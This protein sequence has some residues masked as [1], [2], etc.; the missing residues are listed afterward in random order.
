[1][2]DQP[3]RAP[4][5][6]GSDSHEQE[7]PILD[8]VQ[9]TLTVDPVDDDIAR[10][11]LPTVPAAQ[12]RTKPKMSDLRPLPL[13]DV[14]QRLA[15]LAHAPNSISGHQTVGAKFSGAK[16]EAAELGI[17]S[18]VLGAQ[19]PDNQGHDSSW[20]E[21]D[22]SPGAGYR[23]TSLSEAAANTRIAVHS[24]STRT[25]LDQSYILTD[26]EVV[27]LQGTS[28]YRT[29]LF[30]S[31]PTPST[32][33]SQAR[34]IQ[35]S[36]P[37]TGP[38]DTDYRDDGGRIASWSS[39][40]AL[41]F[42]GLADDIAQAFQ[43]LPEV[44]SNAR[45]FV[46]VGKAGEIAAVD[47]LI[48]NGFELVAAQAHVRTQDGELRIIDF[49]VRNERGELVAVEVKAN[50]AKRSAKQRRLDAQIALQGGQLRTHRI[51]YRDLNYGD[52][53]F[54]EPIEVT[55]IVTRVFGPHIVK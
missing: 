14:G 15:A 10:I 55:V 51:I 50:T 16:Q 48:R 52:I 11:S 6:H 24:P 12:H 27:R 22:S 45:D 47:C 4:R 53:I 42:A 21:S 9:P 37:S 35:N 39:R 34:L 18:A 5:A 8:A 41:Q 19:Q 26:D 31:T 3:R 33:L 54:P 32:A 28:S 46:A 43:D 1:M 20:S 29:R 23:N 13:G 38:Y 25:P 49:L 36:D 30:N 17:P 44:I 40:A 2:A 7:R